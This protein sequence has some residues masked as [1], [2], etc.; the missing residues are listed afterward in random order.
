MY[1]QCPSPSSVS[2]IIMMPSRRLPPRERLGVERS[3]LHRACTCK[4]RVS[5]NA[6]NCRRLQHM[7]DT[8]MFV[9]PCDGPGV[10]AITAVESTD[11]H[12]VCEV[13]TKCNNND[14]PPTVKESFRA[15]CRNIEQT[16]VVP[17]R[18]QAQVSTT[19]NDTGYCLIGGVA[20]PMLHACR[21]LVRR[22]RA[23]NRL[24]RSPP[25]LIS[26]LPTPRRLESVSRPAKVR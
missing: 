17:Y 12:G 25:L 16:Q 20:R 7:T 22:R 11:G 14:Q 18:R 1:V 15:S 4:Y 26:T 9:D 23:R 5:N 8:S 2:I 13:V 3:F 21:L 24:I 10:A 6:A 19:V